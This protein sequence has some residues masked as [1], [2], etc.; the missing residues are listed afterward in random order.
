MNNANKISC[1]VLYK[2]KDIKYH[3]S[4]RMFQ[5]CPTVAVTN[6]GRIYL[7]WY[8]GGVREPHMNNYNLLIYSDDKGAT[9]SEPL[10]VIPS[11]YEYNIHALD[12]QL[13]VDPDGAL[14]VLWVQNNTAPIPENKPKANAGQPLVF[15]DGY[16]FNDF[17]HSEWETVCYYPDAENPEF[18]EPHNIYQGFLR[19]KPTFL[20]NGDWICFAYDQLTDKYGYSITSDKGQTFSHY[21]GAKKLSTDFDEAMA[22]Q[23]KDGSVRMFA[24]TDLGELAECLSY[25]NG[26]TWS[27]AALSGI[28]AAGTRFFVKRLPSGRILLICNEDRKIRKNMT[29][30]LSEDDGAS[31]KYKKCIDTREDISYPDAD[32]FEGKIYLTYDRGRSTHKEILFASFTEQDIIENNDITVKTVSKPPVL[33]KKEEVLR[34]IEEKKIIAI[35]RGIPEEKLIPVAQAL[36]DGGIRILEIPYSADGSVSDEETALHI[37]KLAEHF[38]GKMYIGAGTVLN[39][40][41]VRL[42]KAAGGT[43]IVSPNTDRKVIFETHLCGMVSIPGAFTPSEICDAYSMGADFVKLFPAA[44]VSPEYVKAVKAPLSH[45][46]LLAVGG[47]VENNMTDYLKAGVS[48]FGLGSNLVDK[49]M[50]DALDLEGITQLAIRYV[51]LIDNG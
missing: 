18:S 7:G 4:I 10:L 40:K 12:I 15:V 27:N 14:H 23:R 3:E 20:K 39:Q 35:M 44:S 26:K 17:G 49:K 50:I 2:P 24:R 5:G 19:C 6:G 38:E 32:Y 22:Y 41:Q 25:D 21:Y 48:G 28:V 34:I 16:M 1:D 42:T 11:S 31:W 43:L 51:R 8:S 29:V 47:V 36:Y 9:W 45:I 46:K 37:K 13:F 33:P 30:C